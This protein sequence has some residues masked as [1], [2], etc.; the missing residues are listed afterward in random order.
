MALTDMLDTREG[1]IIVSIVLGLGLAAMFKRVCKSGRCVVIKGPPV[2]ETDE[3]FYKIRN[4]CY[5]YT[6]YVVPC[7][8]GA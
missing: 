3:Y 5:K 6:P 2:K 1:Q 7:E 8:G 4:D